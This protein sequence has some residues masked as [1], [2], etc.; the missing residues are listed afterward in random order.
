M[1]LQAR[2]ESSEREDSERPV[3]RVCL[4]DNGTVD[5]PIDSTPPLTSVPAPTTE[6]ESL[7]ENIE[8]VRNHSLDILNLSVG[9]IANEDFVNPFENELDLVSDF[10]RPRPGVIRD[11]SLGSELVGNGSKW[12]TT[13]DSKIPPAPALSGVR[14]N[15]NSHSAISKLHEQEQQ[16]RSGTNRTIRNQPCSVTCEPGLWDDTRYSTLI[17]R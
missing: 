11:T 7:P 12:T 6:I 3:N 17:G 2:G 14:F 16:V 9:D 1:S 15:K 13:S 4:N 8:E 10:F 5:S